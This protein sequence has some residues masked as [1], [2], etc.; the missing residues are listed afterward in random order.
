MQFEEDIDND[1]ELAR[2]VDA[3]IDFC[4]NNNI[5]SKEDFLLYSQ[6]LRSM[7]DD[8]LKKTDDHPK[9]DKKKNKKK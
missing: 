1:D 9:A 4:F 6:K 5:K 7:R 8:V 2:T 3:V